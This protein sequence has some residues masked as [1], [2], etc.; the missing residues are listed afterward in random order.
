MSGAPRVLRTFQTAVSDPHLRSL[1][2]D[3][4]A[5]LGW[6]AVASSG[7]GRQRGVGPLRRAPRALCAGCDRDAALVVAP[8]IEEG[9]ADPVLVC[10][11]HVDQT[12]LAMVAATSGPV[13]SFPSRRTWR[14]WWRSR[15]SAVAWRNARARV[16]R[17]DVEAPLPPQT[18]PPPRGSLLFS[19]RPQQ[20]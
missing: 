15:P 11:L 19:D 9:A 14:V 7:H 6:A 20:W 18:T 16:R 4:R 8:A 17:D 12:A 5:W 10:G 2:L 13:A 1:A 3:G